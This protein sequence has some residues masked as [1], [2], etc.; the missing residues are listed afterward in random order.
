MIEPHTERYSMGEHKSVKFMG[1]AAIERNGASITVRF[2]LPDVKRNNVV[3]SISPRSIVFFLGGDDEGEN[4][5]KEAAVHFLS[6]VA[7]PTEI[8]PDEVKA[9]LE[10]A[11]LVLVMPISASVPALAPSV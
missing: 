1:G 6:F 7:L 5:K 10:G 9:A 2:P 3:A 4:N 8:K 11:T